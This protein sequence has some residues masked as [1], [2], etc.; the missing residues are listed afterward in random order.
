MRRI[1]F[2]AL[3]GLV[4]LFGVGA[5]YVYTGV[6]SLEAI[7]VTADVWMLQGWGG[8]VAVLR[9]ERGAVVVDT[10]NFRMQGDRIRETAEALAGGPVQAVINTHYHA[11]HT[12]GNP[13]F[14][15]G[16]HVVATARTL[17]HLRAVDA[18][19]WQGEAA[20]TLP[21]DTFEDVHELRFGDK[22]VRSHHL[23]RGHTD[24]DLVTVLVEDRVIVMGDLLF[25][26]RYP[27]IDSEAG[28]SIREWIPTLDRAL[29]LD[30]DQ[31]I[32]GHGPLT[33]AAGIRAFQDFLRELLQVG[34]DAA[35]AGLSLDET[36]A[37]AKLTTDEG[38]GTIG[39]PLVFRIDRDSAVRQSWEEATGADPSRESP[40]GTQ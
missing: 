24:G 35:A 40:G 14:A 30:F 29:E 17:E 6:Q 36:L 1:L 16:T 39:V 18:R 25:R 28:G 13:G 12:H 20:A 4:V 8:N 10:M 19:Y 23:G 34:S 38:F 31:A 37:Q 11:D 22:T 7:P 32:P 3:G 2:V 21:N 26:H 15:P 9:T 27:R 33:D 5:I